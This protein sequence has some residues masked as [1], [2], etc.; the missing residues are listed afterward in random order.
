MC[1]WAATNYIHHHLPYYYYRQCI[2]GFHS[3]TEVTA[4]ATS[5]CFIIREVPD[6]AIAKAGIVLLLIV[7]TLEGPV[8]H[9]PLLV[10]LVLSL[11]ALVILDLYEIM[12]TN[13]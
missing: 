10:A 7:S 11:L 3:L 2:W 6:V 5:A 8:V 13:Q 1:P 12:R 4:I 9:L